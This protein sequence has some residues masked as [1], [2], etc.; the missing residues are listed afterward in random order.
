[1]AAANTEDKKTKQLNPEA[2]AKNWEQRLHRELEAPHRWSEAWGSLFEG[3]I[4]HEY[5]PRIEHL[6]KKLKSMPG[7]KELP[8]YG[9][10]ERFKEIG[11]K[12]FRRKKMFYEE[13]NL[14]A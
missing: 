3:E 8:K 7:G 6:E 13:E 4:P 10:G 14:D 2:E 11:L 5:K 12:D 9:C 1:M